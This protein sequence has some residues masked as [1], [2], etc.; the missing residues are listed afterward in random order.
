MNNSQ[1]KKRQRGKAL[2]LYAAGKINNREFALFQFG[3]ASVC[4]GILST[5]E[6]YKYLG[7][8]WHKRA[9]DPS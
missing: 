7:W 1:I 8:R 6:Y 3:R 2:S 4:C 5:F 9:I